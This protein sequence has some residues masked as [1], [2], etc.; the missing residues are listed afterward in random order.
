[1]MKVVVEEL[2]EVIKEK[3]KRAKKR[4]KDSESSRRNEESRS[5]EFERWW[6]EDWKRLSIEGR[7]GIYAEG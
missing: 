1:M 6:M 5:K 3:R 7:E 2:E 4:Q